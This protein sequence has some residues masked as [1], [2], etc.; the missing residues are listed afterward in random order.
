MANAAV[1][2]RS[3]HAR[4]IRHQ[5]KVETIVGRKF[6]GSYGSYVIA[7]M[8]HIYLG[9]TPRSGSHELR[10]REPSENAAHQS[11]GCVM[12]NVLVPAPVSLPCARL[13]VST[14]IAERKLVLRVLEAGYP[15]Q[16]QANPQREQAAEKAAGGGETRAPEL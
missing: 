6:Y 9:Y 3:E 11:S 15:P 13:R 12:V 10:L 14:R 4:S 1:R 8:K 7:V 2:F 5:K 16:S